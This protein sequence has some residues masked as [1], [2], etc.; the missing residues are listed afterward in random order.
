MAYGFI[1]IKN[2]DEI[3]LENAPRLWY[4][5]IV[6]MHVSLFYSIHRCPEWS[7]VWW[8]GLYASTLERGDPTMVG[9]A[10][11]QQLLLQPPVH[12]SRYSTGDM[13]SPLVPRRNSEYEHAQHFPGFAY[14]NG[15]ATTGWAKWLYPSESLFPRDDVCVRKAG[16]ISAQPI[17][18]IITENVFEWEWHSVR[19]LYWCGQCLQCKLPIQLFLNRN[20]CESVK[21]AVSQLCLSLPVYHLSLMSII[22]QLTHLLC[23]NVLCWPRFNVNMYASHGVLLPQTG[24]LTSNIYTTLFFF[25]LHQ[26]VLLS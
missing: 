19:C 10:L 3:C 25:C 17:F 9:C 22:D 11:G 20:H 2:E 1:N 14:I 15:E 7:P 18:N 21:Q 26:S 6:L 13:Y 16:Q 24:C 12:T 4:F 8:T 5:A 23:K